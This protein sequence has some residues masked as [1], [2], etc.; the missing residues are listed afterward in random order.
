M[1]ISTVAVMTC[2]LGAPERPIGQPQLD[3]LPGVWLIRQVVNNPDLGPPQDGTT[4]AC[5]TKG[6]IQLQQIVVPAGASEP[7]C[8]VVWTTETPDQLSYQTTCSGVDL[9]SASGT[10]YFNGKSFSGATRQKKIGTDG[11]FASKSDASDADEV[12]VSSGTVTASLGTVGGGFVGDSSYTGQ[13]KF[14]VV[15]N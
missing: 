4:Q 9:Q 2:L 5:I 1:L 3:M 14:K 6:M 15:I 11:S 8:N 10:Y 13:I 12:G 7:A